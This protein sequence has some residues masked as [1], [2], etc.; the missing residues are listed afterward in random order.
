MNSSVLKPF[1]VQ[2][3][4]S[5]I[6]CMK[7]LDDNAHK[8]LCV[9]DSSQLLIGTVTDGDIRRWILKGQSLEAGIGPVS[10]SDPVSRPAESSVESLRETMLALQIESIPLVDEE[11]RVVG[12][13]FWNE[14][15]GNA[16]SPVRLRKLD[17][18][19]VIMAGGF[20]T[21]LEPFTTIL[22]KPLIPI[23]DRSIVEHI[24]DRFRAHGVDSFH[25][26]LNHKSRIVQAYFEDIEREWQISF[27]TEERPLGT[28]GSLKLLTDRLPDEFIV[29]NCDIVIH[30]DY[31]DF[32]DHHR[33]HGYDI[34]LVSSMMHYKIPYGIC[35]IDEGGELMEL[36]EKPEYSFLIST[37]MYL[38]NKSVLDLI[39]VGVKYDI[40]Q[41]MDSVKAEGGKVG[42][43]PIRETAW[44]DTGQW[45]EYRK[46]VQ[47]L[48]HD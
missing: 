28:A 43:Y 13:A 34:T 18:P 4:A 48:Q 15:F 20:G 46:T 5:V 31:A 14:L 21:R 16:E 24:I 42:V 23:G 25:L 1:L 32:L 44:D 19:V 40:T 45:E 8:I 22:P 47:R 39:P 17:I 36:K 35:E 10:N 3:D 30:A 26:T 11:N 29:T 6:E 38:L 33:H 37:G 41:L 2:A 7:R 27:V 12:I 9:V